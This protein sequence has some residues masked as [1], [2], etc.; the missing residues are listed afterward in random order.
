VAGRVIIDTVIKSV[1]S[2]DVR[3]RGRLVW[4]V[5]DAPH[6]PFV[7][8]IARCGAE[9][10]VED[11]RLVGFEVPHVSG[12]ADA[13]GSF[14]VPEASMPPTVKPGARVTVVVVDEPVT[15]LPESA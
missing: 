4:A 6:I 11:V 10:R 8:A 5:V 1:D 7:G 2:F 14:A 12:A 13:F 15:G 9:L 3:G